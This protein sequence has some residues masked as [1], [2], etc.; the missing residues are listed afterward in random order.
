MTPGSEPFGLVALEAINFDT[1]ALISKQSGV[2]EVL[3]HALKFD[4]WDVNRMADLIVNSL[5]HEELR[6]DMVCNARE[7][8]KK[9]RWDAA[10]QRTI[11][12]YSRFN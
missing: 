2:A 4:F 11:E 3:S 8:L 6:S 7:E 10:A 9:I 1:P 12:V 5:N